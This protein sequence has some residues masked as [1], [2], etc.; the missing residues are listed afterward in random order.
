MWR[1]ALLLTQLLPFLGTIR[2]TCDN[3]N[4][5]NNYKEEQEARRVSN[6]IYRLLSS[7][8]KGFLSSILFLGWMKELSSLCTEIRYKERHIASDDPFSRGD[9]SDDDGDERKMQHCK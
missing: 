5:N 1:S 3:N 7:E 6:A 9:M 8:V 4:S 2:T